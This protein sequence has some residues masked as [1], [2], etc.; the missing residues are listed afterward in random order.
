M[1]RLA[2]LADIHGNLPALDAVL[3]DLQRREKPDAVWVLGDLVAFFPWLTETIDRLRS[4]PCAACL[5]GNT[6]RY[7]VTGQRHVIPIRSEEDWA[8]APQM[9]TLRDESFRWMTAQLRYRDFTFLRSLPDRL[10]LS[11][12]GFGRVV[13]VHAAPGDDEARILPSTPEE[14]I[15]R[16]L[17]GNDQRLL[18]FG[19]THV[20]TQRMVDGVLLV[21]PGSVGFST[22]NNAKAAYA[23]LEFHKSECKVDQFQVDYDIELV[24]NKLQKSGYPGAGGL[25]EKI[26]GRS[27]V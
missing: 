7:L 1:Y 21:N 23:V 26:S 8:Q 17:A 11:I 15:R 4:I 6:D 25:I 18:L 2:V 20:P 12:Q 19:H 10:E 24:I 13:G 22:E 14:E 9:L 27:N 5:W 3:D 16:Y